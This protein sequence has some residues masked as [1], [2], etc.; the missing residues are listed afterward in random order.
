[1]NGLAGAAA[2]VGRKVEPVACILC[3]DA[4]VGGIRDLVR[5]PR[6]LLQVA[7]VG[8]QAEVVLRED[9]SRRESFASG[10]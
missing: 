8:R 9:R 4:V 5:R 7:L 1:V 3:V 6:L 2:Q 10:C